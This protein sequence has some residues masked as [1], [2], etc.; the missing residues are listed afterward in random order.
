MLSKVEL[1]G[2]TEICTWDIK[3]I[4]SPVKGN[5]FITDVVKIMLDVPE[6]KDP[7]F[8]SSRG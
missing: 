3:D 1:K 2:F 5:N 4:P 8:L 6:H 7:S